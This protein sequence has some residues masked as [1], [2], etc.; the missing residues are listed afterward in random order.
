M[1]PKQLETTVNRLAK[2][3][4][5]ITITGPRQKIVVYGGDEAV[6]TTLGR[7]IGLQHVNELVELERGGSLLW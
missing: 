4:P 5:V 7:F 6:Q 3:L 1:I 2:G